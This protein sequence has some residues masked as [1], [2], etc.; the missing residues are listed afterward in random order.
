MLSVKMKN[1]TMELSWWDSYAVP[2]LS[3][4]SAEILPLLL[5]FLLLFY[6]CY[7]CVVCNI[8]DQNIDS[9]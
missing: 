7:C 8:L 4:E 9:S 3:I 6:L 5:L 1:I 2:L